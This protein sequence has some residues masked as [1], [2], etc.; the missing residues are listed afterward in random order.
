M[1]LL[2]THILPYYNGLGIWRGNFYCG[3]IL[4]P[5][6]YGERAVIVGD[7]DDDQHENILGADASRIFWSENIA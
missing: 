3:P 6:F 7:I 1:Y 5:S 2:I 4:F